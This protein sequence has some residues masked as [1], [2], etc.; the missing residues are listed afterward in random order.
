M[1]YCPT[2]TFLKGK[3]CSQEKLYI[4]DEERLKLDEESSNCEISGLSQPVRTFIIILLFIIER[5]K[6]TQNRRA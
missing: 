3:S 6:Y 1:F 5:F 2:A 4:M